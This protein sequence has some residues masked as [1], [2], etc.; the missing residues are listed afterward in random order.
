MTFVLGFP[1]LI[2]GL[3]ALLMQWWLRR[4][5]D[6]SA[7]WAL[8]AAAAVVALA[9][10]GDLARARHR[11][12][13]RTTIAAI[14]GVGACA[15]LLLGG[16]KELLQLRLVADGGA[17][18]VELPGV[19]IVLGIMLLAALGGTLLLA[20]DALAPRASALAPTLARRALMLAAALGL[21]AV[22]L[23][24]KAALAGESVVA[25]SRIGAGLLGA[26]LLL[27]AG[28]GAALAEDLPGDASAL[29]ARASWL[30][31]L[32][33]AL[34]VAALLAAGVTAW[35]EQASYLAGSTRAVLVAAL[36]GVAASQ[37]TGLRLLR[38]LVFAGLLVA[39]VAT[40]V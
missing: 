17:A 14:G 9:A 33:G 21:I 38:T 6:L 27:A 19:G 18:P 39:A 20:A 16:G 7:P 8:A 11:R 23:I 3:A 28:T 10:L 13:D 2:A 32:A 5:S 34:A 25:F 29:D 4:P 35:L 36:A 26:T 37:P 1:F 30:V 31:R 15:L 12:G 22:G 40:G 24:A